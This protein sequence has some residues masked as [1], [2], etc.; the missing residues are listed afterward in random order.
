MR[1]EVSCGIIPLK[2]NALNWSVLLVQHHTGSWWG[3]PKG[4]MEHGEEPKQTAERELLEET[5]LHLVR[6]IEH[7][8]IVEIYQFQ[9]K[10]RHI[11]KKV[12]YFFA[13][14]DGVLRLQPNEIVSARWVDI[15]QAE[16]LATFEGMKRICREICLCLLPKGLQEP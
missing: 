12:I 7:E 5:G 10:G 16:S 14:V 6:W 1:Y 11:Q 9:R 15:A 8:E 3:F 4:H 2:K 13:E